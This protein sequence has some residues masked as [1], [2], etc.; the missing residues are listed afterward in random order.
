MEDASGEGG[1]SD[2]TLVS[3]LDLL[4]RMYILEVIPGWLP[5]ARSPKRVASKPKRYLADPSLAVAVLGMSPGALMAD[6]Q[7]F[8]LVFENL[9]MRDLA[10][11]AGALDPAAD[12]PV[13]YYRDGAGLEVDAI[14]ELA[15]GRW[16]AFEI[17]TS[18]AKAPEAVENL[19]RLRRKLCENPSSRT[20]PPEFM[21]VLTGVS[22][23]A[24][25]VDEGIYV[26][27]IGSLTA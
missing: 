1:T 22:S 27:P 18:E 10:V 24:R 15:D 25:R 23:C 17:K 6:W 5:P 20:R 19:R 9:C 3:Y 7:T 16:A 8:G 14:V 2:A 12:V 26:V 13:R 11:Y 21:A 4:R